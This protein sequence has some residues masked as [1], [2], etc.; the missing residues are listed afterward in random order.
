MLLD[1]SCGTRQ[2]T[3]KTD[4]TR[5]HTSFF[6]HECFLA[7]F[8]LI[9]ISYSYSGAQVSRWPPLNWFLWAVL[10]QE[11]ILVDS[12]VSN[13]NKS[14]QILSLYQC[15]L[16]GIRRFHNVAD[17]LF[18]LLHPLTLIIWDVFFVLYP[19]L[20]TFRPTLMLLSTLISRIFGW[21]QRKTTLIS[22]ST[23][24]ERIYIPVEC[25]ILVVL[26]PSPVNTLAAPLRG[27]S[28]SIP[29]CLSFHGSHRV[30]LV[31]HGYIVSLVTHG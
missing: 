11:T 20:H 16:G 4:P 14:D 24:I 26:R 30:P 21:M 5:E 12:C 27:R 25:Q 19:V 10:L 22:D 9:Y 15:W 28:W 31:K 6:L 8:G 3:S 2:H 7:L 1:T 29:S 13:D 23:L 18:H 17:S